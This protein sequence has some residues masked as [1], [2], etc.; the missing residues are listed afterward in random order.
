MLPI[1]TVSNNHTLAQLEENITVSIPLPLMS[2][3]GIT[4][5]IISG[6]LPNGLRLENNQILGTPAEVDRVITSTV[7]IRATTDQGIADRTFLIS[8][9][10]PDDPQ[11]ITAEGRL[12]IG[13]NGVFFILDNSLIDFQLLANDPDLPA[14][15]TLQFRLTGGELPPGI[16]LTDSGKLTG[17]VDPLLA[18]EINVVN[19]NYDE[20][21]LD[22]LPYDFGAGLDPNSRLPRKLNR[23]YFFRVTV[24]D[25]VSAV[26]RQF[27]IFIVGDDFARSDNT[28]MKAADGVFTADFTFLRVPLWLTPGNLGTRRANNYLTIFL[29]AF[30]S[31]TIAGELQYFLEAINDDGTASVLPP[32]LLLDPFTGELAGRVP[33]QSAVT[34]DYNFTINAVRF[35][36]ELGLFTVFGTFL[37]DVFAN[38]TNTLRIGK[39]PRTTVNGLTELQSLVG[40]T[41]SIGN[42]EY[43][44]I[45]V[46]ETNDEF[47]TITVDRVIEPFD[48][49]APLKFNNEVFD[50]FVFENDQFGVPEVPEFVTAPDFFFVDELNQFDRN[51]YFKR[52][53]RYSDIENYIIDEIYP[54]IKWEISSANNEPLFLIGNHD[55]SSIEI[56]LETLFAEGTK[57]A[58]VN[59]ERNSFDQAIGIKLVIPATSQNRN[60]SYIESL[61]EAADGSPVNATKVIE[62]DRVKLN[63]IIFGNLNND[64]SGMVT[65]LSLAVFRGNSFNQTFS[66]IEEEVA[67]KKKTFS[68]KLL[69]EVDSVVAWLTPTNIGT[70]QANRIST[71]FVRAQ[72]T[73]Q[74]SL[75]RYSVIQGSLPPGLTL[76]QDGEIIGKVPVTGTETTPGLIRFADKFLSISNITGTF[77][78]QDVI[79]SSVTGAEARVIRFDVDNGR[80]YYNYVTVPAPQIFTVGETVSTSTASATIR[81]SNES[82]TTFDFGNTTFDREYKFTVLA[83]D[84]FEYSAVERE[85]TIRI[86][87]EDNLN[88]SNIFFKPFLSTDQ[89]R[90]FGNFVD[91][92][93]IFAP[94]AVYRPGDPNFGIQ[95]T[96]RCLVYAGIE[97]LDLENYVAATAKNHKRK[98]FY[99]GKLKTAVAK[100]PGTNQVLYEVVY[101]ELVDRAQSSQGLSDKIQITSK[102]RITVDSVNFETKDDNTVSQSSISGVTV[103]LNS[104][105]L[106]DIQVAITVLTNDSGNII[107]STDNLEILLNSG[108]TILVQTESIDELI[109]ANLLPDRYRPTGNT[110]KADSNAVTLDQSSDNV[111][112]T[113]SIAAMRQQIKNINIDN[114]RAVS[115]RDFLPLWMRTP[116]QDSLSELDYVLALPI[117]YTKPGNS[118]IIKENIE[119]S[120][121]DFNILNFDID[122]YII[123]NT[124]DINREQYILFANYQFNV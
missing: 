35:N 84:R 117:A 119:N 48:G 41:I 97:N 102:N 115:N 88:Y 27:Q 99:P 98:K 91:N 47:D 75:I 11:W 32:G 12:P 29:D 59:I 9:E 1:W 33:Y 93:R 14:G 55:S 83:K 94:D 6:A 110:I 124:K 118:K 80:L 81:E 68:I 46:N 114:R 90:E 21:P 78:D 18:L 19:G 53:L 67:S 116:Q 8:V 5:K 37:D 87:D 43:N 64:L 4:T 49:V 40:R 23:E 74:D 120:N 17:I 26:T 7:V 107:L 89:R 38:K 121:F 85:F 71:L 13:P 122:R 72:T 104:E 16:I 100:L 76:S 22:V 82:P 54:Y 73:V 111:K 52:N 3:E 112:Y 96:L 20:V 58:Y 2:T 113:S 65:S 51:F 123:D 15:D 25:N 60:K 101:V 108:L 24:S 92:A 28:I 34:K 105:N 61:F 103:L 39:V 31:N 77:N 95:K 44:I 62:V 109:D 57:D 86:S 106:T 63:Q 10:G 36:A 70:L 79:V 45:S 66:R 42:R 50:N 30:E 69:G 56:E